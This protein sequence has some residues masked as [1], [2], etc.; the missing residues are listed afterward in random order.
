[1]HLLYCDESNLE[2]RNGDFFFYGGLSIESEAASSLSQDIDTLRRRFN[3]PQ[4]YKLKFNPGP[5]DLTNDQ[6]ISLKQQTIEIAIAH[7]AKLFTS[8]ILHDIA[9]SPDEAR[10]N[11]INRICYHFNCYLSR[12]ESH[13]LVLIDRFNDGLIDQHLVDKFLIGIQGLPYTH[14]QRL[15]KI[16]GFHYS[17]IGQSHMTSVIDIVIGSLRYSLNGYT[18]QDA[19]ALAAARIILPILSPLFFRNDGQENI[20]DFGVFFSPRTINSQRYRAIYEGAKRF[21]SDNGVNL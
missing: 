7:G 17:A 20:S 2:E 12:I 5:P 13:G 15:T 8:L 19:T 10:R 21:F 4:N 16:I 11:E 3:L 9:T 6:F 14:E 18:R 1:M